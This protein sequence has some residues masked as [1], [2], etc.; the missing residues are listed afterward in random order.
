MERNS[1]DFIRIFILFLTHGCVV[2]WNNAVH[3]AGNLEGRIHGC[4][5]HSLFRLD[6]SRNDLFYSLHLSGS[7][8]ITVASMDFLCPVHFFGYFTA[9]DLGNIDGRKSPWPRQT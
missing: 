3:L 5:V 6:H 4:F 9:V 2:Q 8:Y 7:A 1:E